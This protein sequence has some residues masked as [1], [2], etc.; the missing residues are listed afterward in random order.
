MTYVVLKKEKAGYLHNDMFKALLFSGMELAAMGCNFKVI[1]RSWMKNQKSEIGPFG[2][3]DH[4]GLNV[5]L[6][7]FEDNENATIPETGAGVMIAM[8]RER[9]EKGDLGMKTGKGFYTYPDP[10]FSQP[11]FMVG[12]EE[13]R[14]A[15]TFML[16]NVLASAISLVAGDYGSIRDVDRSWM[17]THNPE[18]GPFG[19][20]DQK[21]LDIMLTE[22]QQMPVMDETLAQERAEAIAFLKSYVDRGDL[23]VKTGKGFYTY[24]D[25]AF[26][27]KDFLMDD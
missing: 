7:I 20:I 26:L 9:V 24:P 19:M 21:G 22:L 25:A 8:L 11:E 13:N 16:N 3:F 5:P 10:E 2:L 15:S 17:L 12:G 18:M 1:D 14:D 23:G 27:K 4:V 6:D